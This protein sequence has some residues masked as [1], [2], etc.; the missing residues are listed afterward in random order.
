M[1]NGPQLVMGIHMKN[2][3]KNKDYAKRALS[4]G[5]SGI[6]RQ[7]S[8]FCVTIL[9]LPETERWATTKMLRPIY[10]WYLSYFTILKRLSELPLDHE[11]VLF[12]GY[13]VFKLFSTSLKWYKR[14]YENI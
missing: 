2:V 10:N 4:N 8:F 13:L 7:N 9:G 6:L 3:V 14:D 12:W 1:G 11:K 5:S